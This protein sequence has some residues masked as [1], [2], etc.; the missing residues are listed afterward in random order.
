MRWD[1]TDGIDKHYEVADDDLHGVRIVRTTPLPSKRSA[2]AGMVLVTA[3]TSE[4]LSSAE[5]FVSGVD[6]LR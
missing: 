2:A 6:G 3:S 5:F 1:D 4:R